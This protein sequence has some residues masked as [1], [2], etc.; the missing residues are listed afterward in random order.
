VAG[1]LGAGLWGAGSTVI[2]FA[3]SI[4]TITRVEAAFAAA[5]AD[6]DLP[7]RVVV[8]APRNLGAHVSA[9]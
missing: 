2:A 4:R 7:G 1:A 8:I 3:D 5:A 6:T 9:G